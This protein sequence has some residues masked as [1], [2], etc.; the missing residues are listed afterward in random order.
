M[1][2][3]LVAIGGV[4]ACAS[5]LGAPT[6]ARASSHR[7]APLIAGDPQ[8]DNTDVYAFTSPDDANSVTLIANW[9]PFEEPNGGPNFYPFAEGAQYNINIDN[10]ASATPN[11][12]YRWTFTNHRKSVDTFLYNTGVVNNITDGTLNFTQTYNLEMIA[13]GV[14]PVRLLTDAPVAPSDV[15]LASMPNYAALR[16]QAISPLPGGGKSFTGQ[17]DDPFFLDLRIFDLLYGAPSMKEVGHDTLAGYNVNSIA[18]QVPKTALAVGGD[19][20]SIIGV[21]S[22]T[23][24]QNVTLSADGTRPPSGAP[25]QVSRLGNPLVNEVVVPVGSKDLFNASKPID[26]AQ[27]LPKV[28]DPE[29]PKLIQKLYGIPAP[30][31]PRDDLV[32]VFLTGVPGLNQP[33]GFQSPPPTGIAAGKDAEELRLNMST[34]TSAS[35]N[36]LGVVG[37]DKAGFPNGRRLTDDVVDIE[38]QALEGI[39]RPSPPAGVAALGDGVNANDS[40]FGATFPYLALPHTAAVNQ[41]NTQAVNPGPGPSSAPNGGTPTGPNALPPTGEGGAATAAASLPMLP[42]GLGAAGLIV[43]ILGFGTLVLSRRRA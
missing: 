2:R 33:P 17:A 41:G 32:Q 26:D 22:T 43:A 9:I 35:P 40:A 24:R 10:S 34:P 23:D 8:V 39:L 14:A 1:R 28:Q 4:L 18:L 12:T 30:A 19:G 27:F 20:S 37:G 38:L 29:V 15:G 5:L 3:Q 13:K 7:E 16:D 42:I 21:Y 25:V 36:R 31:T 6:G 11:I